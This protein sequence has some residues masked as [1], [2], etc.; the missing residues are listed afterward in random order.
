MKANSLRYSTRLRERQRYKIHAPGKVDARH[1]RARIARLGILGLLFLAASSARADVV[2]GNYS[3]VNGHAPTFEKLLNNFPTVYTEIGVPFQVPP[4]F[5]YKLDNIEVTGW[6]P[7]PTGTAYEL[8]KAKIY[9]GPNSNG[10]LDPL[11]S[12]V[13]NFTFK[14]LSKTTPG[15]VDGLSLSSNY[16]GTLLAGTQYWLLMQIAGNPGVYTAEAR[17]M[18]NNAGVKGTILRADVN[19]GLNNYIPT[20]NAVLPVFRVLGTPVTPQSVKPSY[21]SYAA[22][23]AGGSVTIYPEVICPTPLNNPFSMPVSVSLPPNQTPA[24]VCQILANAINNCVACPCWGGIGCPPSPP[25]GFHA[26]CSGS[27]LRVTNSATGVCPG[28]FVCADHADGLTNYSAKKALEGLSGAIAMEVRGVATGVPRDPTADND[29]NVTRTLRSGPDSPPQV[30]GGRVII[31]SGM[32][33]SRIRQNLAAAFSSQGDAG[34]VVE[35]NRVIFSPPGQGDLNNIAANYD[36]A[37]QVNDTGLEYA[38]SPPFSYSFFDYV[39]RFATTPTPTPTPAPTPIPTLSKWGWIILILALVV[40]GTIFI[41]R[42]KKR[43]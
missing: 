31:T 17:W 25:Y 2:Y 41:L 30:F 9:K 11:W 34:V 37:F 23:S 8:I 22:P 15:L 32:E 24:Q 13:G 33:A 27:V 43:A 40:V 42:S 26:D 18:H 12:H 14:K 10:P 38:F 29:V 5:D 7:S 16:T 3:P 39:A 20:P 1:A 21:S 6:Q 4:G 28:A 35:G 19:T 36:I